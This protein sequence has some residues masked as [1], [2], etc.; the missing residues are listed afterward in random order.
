MKVDFLFL[1]REEVRFLSIKNSSAHIWFSVSW[2]SY[3]II[4]RASALQGQRLWILWDSIKDMC[5]FYN[6]FTFFGY[7]VSSTLDTGQG[8]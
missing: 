8:W 4:V 3:W 5:V 2:M 6:I 1:P 7:H